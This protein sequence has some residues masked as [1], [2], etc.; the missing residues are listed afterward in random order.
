MEIA[1]QED[2]L[3]EEEKNN[4][5]AALE[6]LRAEKE[7][8]LDLEAQIKRDGE[9][10][11]AQAK[12]RCKEELAEIA[13]R[14]VA[15]APREEK[16]KIR[17]GEV[18]SREMNVGARETV[19]SQREAVVRERSAQVDARDRAVSAEKVALA[20]DMARHRAKVIADEARLKG[21][22]MIFEQRQAT[23]D[24]TRRA[25]TESA[26]NREAKIQKDEAEVAEKKAKAGAIVAELESIKEKLATELGRRE[27]DLEARERAVQEDSAKANAAKKAA[28][29][30]LEEARR[31]QGGFDRQR[32]EQDQTAR[33]LEKAKIDVEIA[34]AKVA[35]REVLVNSLIEKHNLAEE[36][37]K[38]EEPAS[39]DVPGSGPDGEGG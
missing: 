17:E 16:L 35:K 9:N 28:E 27:L 25:E 6:K 11:Y 32:A 30:K 19:V 18:S 20:E 33:G 29:E 24:A 22:R 21:E 31:I 39:P 3:T 1:A 4:P 12:E 13:R 15:I 5:V 10:L 8:L 23:A 26:L 34:Q 2:I 37:E 7:K 14:E 36:M 38:L